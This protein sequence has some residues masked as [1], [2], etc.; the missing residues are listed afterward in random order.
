M[1]PSDPSRH[2]KRSPG[3]G[4]FLAVLGA[5]GLGTALFPATAVPGSVAGVQ[6]SLLQGALGA[7]FLVLG[8]GIAAWAA[9]RPPP[10][11]PQ[12]AAHVAFSSRTRHTEELR[13]IAEEN[14]ATVKQA[15]G[16]AT[17]SEVEEFD[18]LDEVDE[19]AMQIQDTRQKMNKAKVMLGTGKLSEKAYQQYMTE[20]KATLAELES[21]HMKADILRKG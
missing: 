12:L 11:V 21:K 2:V 19:L 17:A 5:I 4:I 16:I 18:A 9:T 14:A 10:P 8:I 6:L 7:G 15:P 1:A 20:L 13:A 3:G